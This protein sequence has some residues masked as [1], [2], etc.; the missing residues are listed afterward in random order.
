[1]NSETLFL[2]EIV[3]VAYLKILLKTK[4]KSKNR[5]NKKKI[6]K[7][8]KLCHTIDIKSPLLSITIY[9]LS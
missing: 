6:I 9:F 5:A 1:M 3:R 2:L 7:N 4:M 8:S